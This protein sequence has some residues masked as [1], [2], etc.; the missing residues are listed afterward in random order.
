ME[1]RDDVAKL[2]TTLKEQLTGKGLVFESPDRALFREA[3][4]QSGYYAE[5]RQKFGAE[6]WTALEAVVGP[7]S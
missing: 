6:V 5:W 7:L 1:Q 3:L 2:N 4:S